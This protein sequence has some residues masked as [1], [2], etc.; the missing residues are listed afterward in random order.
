MIIHV[1]S[2]Y[3][4][5]YIPYQQ[6]VLVFPNNLFFNIIIYQFPTDRVLH[7]RTALLT[8]GC[9]VL[10]TIPMLQ[11]T[12][13]NIFINMKHVKIPVRARP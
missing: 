9:C 1:I 4:L 8:E 5:T 7:P 12:P 11:I 6:A 2:F 3:I 13:P 10:R